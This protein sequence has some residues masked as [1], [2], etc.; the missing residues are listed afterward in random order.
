MLNFTTSPCVVLLIDAD[1]V[2][3]NLEYILEFSHAQGNLEF[4]KAYGDWKQ[5]PLSSRLNKI[6]SLNIFCKQVDRVGNNATDKRLLSDAHKILEADKTDVF[7]IVSG[8]HHFSPLCRKIQD[9]GRIV[10]GIGNKGNSS[11]QL[12]N[13]CHNFHFTEQMKKCFE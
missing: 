2:H 6:R 11:R 1:N 5:K 10:V 4:C 9:K 8:D 13:A 12:Q 3:K 7:I